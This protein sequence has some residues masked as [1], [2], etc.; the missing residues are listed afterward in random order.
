[1]AELYR[2][3]L[4]IRRFEE[5]LLEL[6]QE[7]KLSGTTHTCIGQEANCVGV[8][9][10]LRDTD[11]IFGNHRSHGHYLAKTDDA[12][13]LLAELMGKPS[14]ICGGLGGSQHLCAPGFKTSGIL[15]STLAPAAGIAWAKKMEDRGDVSVVFVGDGALGQGIV[16]ETLN[17]AALW[18]LPLLIVVENNLWAQSTPLDQHLAGS[19]GDRFRAFGIDTCELNTTDV[20]EINEATVSLLQQMRAEPAPRALVIECYRFAHHSINDD[21]RPQKENDSRRAMDPLLVHGS[22]FTEELK[23]DIASQVDT[24]L[25]HVLATLGV[26]E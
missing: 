13:G 14:G 12:K 6:F 20:V 19:I 15:G 9:S 18:A 4:G 24:H 2:A 8:V 16:Y 21:S 26:S 25:A 1:M 3:M 22:R 17:M 7:G 10:A 11:H 23:L 5:A